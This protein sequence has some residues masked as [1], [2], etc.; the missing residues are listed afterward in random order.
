MLLAK[1]EK[2]EKKK[3]KKS[4]NFSIVSVQPYNAKGCVRGGGGGWQG[5]RASFSSLI[6]MSWGKGIKNTEKLT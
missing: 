3:K 6:E 4:S 1:E 5:V 2:E